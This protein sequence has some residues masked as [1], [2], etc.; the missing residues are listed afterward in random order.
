MV[1]LGWASDLPHNN[2]HDGLLKKIIEHDVKLLSNLADKIGKYFD[3][4]TVKVSYYIY[5]RQ[6]QQQNK[7][8]YIRDKSNHKVLILP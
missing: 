8:Q 4:L 2:I 1:P 6:F 3:F 7:K 5:Y